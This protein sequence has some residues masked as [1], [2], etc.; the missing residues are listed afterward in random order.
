MSDDKMI[1][2][3]EAHNKLK[4]EL[5]EKKH[6]E[7]KLIHML[8]A[9]SSAAIALLIGSAL[10]FLVT[11]NA[12]RTEREI[13]EQL[14]ES[15][16]QAQNDLQECSK[17]IERLETSVFS[18]EQEASKWKDMAER[19]D[20]TILE[21][22]T[23]ITNLETQI[24]L[25][26]EEILLVNQNDRSRGIPH[27]ETDVKILAGMMFAEEEGNLFMAGGAGSVAINRVH[28]PRFPNTIKDV[29]YEKVVTKDAVY[30][31]Y[32]PRTKKIIECVVAGK[33]IPKSLADVEYIPQWYHDLA[34]TL[35]THG[36]M[37]PE[38]VVYQAHFP[39]GTGVFWEW[40]GEYLCFG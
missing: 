18:F 13:N 7:N 38:K 23:T 35:L 3:I 25:L 19:L 9:I 37:L 40:N 34:E 21:M 10:S 12:Y 16:A 36:S 39:Q 11:F 24:S 14:T 26:Q 20:K 1:A 8:V 22:E 5:A 4:K 15:L 17:E 28:D 31:Q 29:I 2:L 27:D 32:A 33:P 30:E 6:K